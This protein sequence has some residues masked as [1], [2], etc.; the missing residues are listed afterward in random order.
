MM[1]ADVEGAGAAASRTAE[2]GAARRWRRWSLAVVSVSVFAFALPAAAKRRSHRHTRKVAP[3][4]VV[5]PASVKTPPV[6]AAGAPALPASQFSPEQMVERADHILRGKTTA[7]VVQMDVHTA[8]F[9]R[10]YEMVS[11]ED[12]RDSTGKVLVKIL[13]PALWRGNGTLKVGSRLTLYNPSTDRLTALSTSMLGESWMG[14]HFTN[15]DLVKLTDLARDYDAELLKSWMAATPDGTPVQ[16][17]QLTLHPKA[18]AAVSWDHILLTVYE[19]GTDLQPTSLAYFRRAGEPAT[20]TLTFSEV[21]GL[22][23]RQVP[24][25]MTMTVATKPGE[26]TKM[27]YRT[28]KFDAPIPPEKFSEQALRQ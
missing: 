24:S 6:Q 16:F 5:T 20:R 25:V 11:W 4:A 18:G 21:K 17:H 1:R 12:D 14:S 2:P 28:L 23:G 7:A 19:E 13:G 3:V 15:D 10:S 26:F 22:G 27:T 9:D 8:S